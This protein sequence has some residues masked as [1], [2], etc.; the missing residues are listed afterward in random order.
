MDSRKPGQAASSR[1]AGLRVARVAILPVLF[2]LL[3]FQYARAHDPGLSSLTI[4][5][6]MNVL[7]ATLTLAVRDAA[8]IAELDQN[9]DGIVTQVEFGRGQAQLEAAVAKQVVIRAAGK[10]VKDKFVHSRLDKNNN[11]EVRLNFDP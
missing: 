2:S 7:E 5:Q 8:Q 3:P 6:H 11:V 4:R 1:L 9:H 10:V